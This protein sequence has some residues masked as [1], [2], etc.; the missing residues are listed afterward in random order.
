MWGQI[1]SVVV[2]LATCLAA[3]ATPVRA[4]VAPPYPPSSWIVDLEWHETL[5]LGTDNDNWP[6]TWADD[7]HVYAAGGDGRNLLNRIETITHASPAGILDC[8]ALS[9][10]MQKKPALYDR[11]GDAHYNLISALHK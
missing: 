9:K 3:T 2:A 4:T 11:D 5:D 7:D 6:T 10:L 8:S 1:A